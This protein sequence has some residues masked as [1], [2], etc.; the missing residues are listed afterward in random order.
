M[1]NLYELSLFLTQ[2]EQEL[3]YVAVTKLAIRDST[4]R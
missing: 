1:G 3:S 2:K 4:K